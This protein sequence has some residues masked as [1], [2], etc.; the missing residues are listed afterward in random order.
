MLIGDCHV[1][2]RV[3]WISK[4]NVHRCGIVLCVVERDKLPP[5][6]VSASGA[7]CAIHGTDADGVRPVTTAIVWCDGSSGAGRRVRRVWVEDLKPEITRLRRSKAA[8]IVA[9]AQERQARK[10]R[11]R[12]SRLAT[13]SAPL[14]AGV[15]FVQQGND[16]P[17]KIGV[18]GNVDKR[19]RSL[20]TSSPLPLRLLAVLPGGRGEEQELHKRLAAHRLGGE[21]FAPV[22][23]V[24]AVAGLCR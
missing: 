9:L 2:M 11:R 3:Q 15:Y 24:L 20:S 1:G 10:E 5:E 4:Q 18:S 7:R 14:T 22:P 12:K 13:N 8:R 16:G 21:W 19:I 23:A 6:A 17:I